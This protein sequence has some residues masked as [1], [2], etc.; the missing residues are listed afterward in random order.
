LLGDTSAPFNIGIVADTYQDQSTFEAGGSIGDGQAGPLLN[1]SMT[2]AA[3][4]VKNLQALLPSSPVPTDAMGQATWA[5][6]FITTFGR[7]AFRRPVLPAESQ[8]LFAL[9]QAQL[10][11]PI[12]ATFPEA[13]AAVIGGM[14]MSP[15][16]LYR[17]ELGPNKPIVQGNLIAFNAYEIASRLSYTIWA[18]MPD[19]ALSAAA[20]NNQL[21]TSDQ[22]QAQ[23][24]RMLAD[25]KAKNGLAEFHM[26][27]LKLTDLPTLNKDS[28]T[29]TPALTTSMLGETREFVWSILG[30]QGD[31]TLTSLLTSSKTFVDPS[32][33]TLYGVPNVTAPG[34]TPVTLDP[35]QRAGLLTE[36]SFLASRSNPDYNNPI[37][38]GVAMLRRLFCQD[39]QKPNNLVVPTIT[40][41]APG[42]TIRQTYDIHGAKACATTCHSIIDPM[43]FAFL[44]Y[45]AL[46]AWT[47]QDQGQPVD[48]SGSFTVN[49]GTPITFK[50]AVDLMQQLAKDAQVSDCASTMWLQYMN[51]RAADPTGDSVS[52]AAA[53]K[54]Q[55]V[56]ANDIR[57]MLVALTN[58]NAFTVRLPNVGENIQ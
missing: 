38:T 56:H 25:P 4:A 3:T 51:R 19:D 58:T 57:E 10:A 26:Q 16:F 40:G 20:D 17:W 37:N 18:S 32:L 8:A 31:G 11:A 1:M 21:S 42:T 7:R 53:R 24:R 47:T 36:A 27:W 29:F 5:Q 12:S 39:I 28:M 13:V 2:L 23:A 55:A 43:G 45:D 48:A 6:T 22:V 46:G 54:A 35:T 52:L 49:G 41:P 50:S 30:P 34:F 14:L 33:A 9:Y 44:N 15:S